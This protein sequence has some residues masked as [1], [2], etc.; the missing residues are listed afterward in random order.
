MRVGTLSDWNRMST[1]VD[2]TFR[3]RTFKT[4]SS[5]IQP[6]AYLP[7]LLRSVPFQYDSPLRFSLLFG[8]DSL[9]GNVLFKLL[10]LLHFCGQFLLSRSHIAEMVQGVSQSCPQLLRYMAPLANIRSST[11]IQTLVRAGCKS[12]FFILTLRMFIA[13]PYKREPG[14]GLHQLLPGFQGD[15]ELQSDTIT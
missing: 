13:G 10:L 12:S 1:K 14:A 3:Q 11:A 9:W 4:S 15:V 5:V 7:L 2:I 6:T 8:V